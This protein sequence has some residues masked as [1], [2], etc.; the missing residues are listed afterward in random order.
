MNRLIPLILVLIVSSCDRFEEEH[1]PKVVVQENPH[2]DWV[3]HSLQPFGLDVSVM[4]PPHLTDKVEIRRNESFGRIELSAGGS[5]DFI[6]SSDF[7]SVNSRKFD[8]ESG[9]FTIEYVED[10][11][12]FILYK[13]ALP[14]GSLPYFNFVKVFDYKGELYAVENNPLVEFSE[15]EVRLMAEIAK[16]LE[17]N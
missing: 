6:M 17:S 15:K 5:V 14:D 11:S 8:L 1:T 4:V 13:A 12:D 2:R 9:I 10:H 7:E 3:D 16:T